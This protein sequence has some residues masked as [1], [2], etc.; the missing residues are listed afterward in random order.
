MERVFVMAPEHLFGVKG[1]IEQMSAT[2]LSG[3]QQRDPD[4]HTTET[5]EQVFDPNPRPC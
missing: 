5:V 1:L 2:K 3:G 4:T